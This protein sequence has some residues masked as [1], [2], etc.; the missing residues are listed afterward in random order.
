MV[1]SLNEAILYIYNGTL[2]ASHAFKPQFKL[3]YSYVEAWLVQGKLTSLYRLKSII[4]ERVL[5]Y[6]EFLKQN[7]HITDVS[8]YVE[9]FYFYR[10]L[11]MEL[12][13]ER[14]NG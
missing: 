7:S 10:Y 1:K 2:P 9:T 8:S 11:F 6:S 4:R 5:S 13:V 3:F 12:F 14:E